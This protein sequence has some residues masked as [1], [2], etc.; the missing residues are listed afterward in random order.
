MGKS[1]HQIVRSLMHYRC[2]K[3]PNV[4]GLWKWLSTVNQYK[5]E[6]GYIYMISLEN[7]SS[8]FWNLNANVGHCK[9]I[10]LYI[11]IYGSLSPPQP[12]LSSLGLQVF[13]YVVVLVFFT[14]GL[15][16]FRQALQG[17]GWDNW[18]YRVPI[19]INENM[20]THL[21]IHTCTFIYNRDTSLAYIIYIHAQKPWTTLQDLS[22]IEFFAG[23]ANVF[24]E[25]K[26]L[27]GSTAL[28]IEYLSAI[29]GPRSN[30]FD[31]LTASGLALLSVKVT[32]KHDMGFSFF[33]YSSGP[34]IYM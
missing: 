10:Y 24:A 18:S 34:Y 12:R 6:S 21:H 5:N 33:L 13:I 19:C 1:I 30:A 7:L 28:D 16:G 17:S 22:F 3:A 31:I 25:V 20:Y 27:Y 4:F 29:G 15:P 23:Q 8:A 14:E 9:S 2:P 11:Y 26:K 32:G